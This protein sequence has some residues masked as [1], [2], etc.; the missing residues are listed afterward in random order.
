MQARRYTLTL[1]VWRRFVLVIAAACAIML[2]GTGYAVVRLIDTQQSQ[3]QLTAQAAAAI[4]ARQ[5]ERAQRGELTLAAAQTAITEELRTMGAAAPPGGAVDGE[6]ASIVTTLALVCGPFGIAFFALAFWL[7]RGISAPLGELTD[8]LQH[9]A[10]GNSVTAVPGTTRNDEVGAIARAVAAFGTQAKERAAQELETETAAKSAAEA[11]HRDMVARLANEFQEAMGAAVGR[12]CTSAK[13]LEKTANSLSRSAGSTQ[14]LSGMVAVS[15]ELTASNVE[16]VAR[17]CEQL[18]IT[19]AEIS[20]QVHAS[21]EIAD[22]ASLQAQNTSSCVAQLSQAA[23]RIGNIIGF[24]N[25]IADQTNLLA[26]NA[27]IEAAHAGEAGRGFAVVAQE[28]KALAQQTAKATGEIAQQISS[29]QS[30]TQTAVTAIAGI[31]STTAKMSEIAGAIAAAVEQQGSSTKEIS[32]NVS[33]AAK[34]TAEVVS[35]INDVTE[36]T[37]ET[38]TAATQMLVSARAMSGESALFKNELEK[39]LTSVRAA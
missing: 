32:R 21:N 17:T 4:T 7:A 36:G 39:F 9:L 10:K 20:K 33:E 15:S 1:T 23:E 29:M 31:T 24:I 35:A 5:L 30:A 16:S 13:D 3:H 26:L 2:A 19:V 6:I 18:A 37:E 11:R 12:V 25:V 28:V 27:T 34:G 14:Q 22:E 38:G 8:S